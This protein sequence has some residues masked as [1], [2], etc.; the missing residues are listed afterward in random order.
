MASRGGASCPFLLYHIY[1][2]TSTLDI[3]AMKLTIAELSQGQINRIMAQP[4]DLKAPVPPEGYTHEQAIQNIASYK[5]E[6]DSHAGSAAM[7]GILREIGM[8]RIVAIDKNVIPEAEKETLAK[9][10]KRYAFVSPDTL[11]D[12][13]QIG[14]TLYVMCSELGDAKSIFGSQ[15]WL[16]KQGGFISQERVD[17]I[18]KSLSGDSERQ[19]DTA[20]AR[21]DKPQEPPE[22]TPEDSV[23]RTV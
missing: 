21:E 19:A 7:I 22:G 1:M 12:A 20:G 2:E 14:F 3:G 6:W 13:Y 17:E 15:L 11:D 4:N 18:L 5:E 23:E 8:A 16:R 9:L 10:C